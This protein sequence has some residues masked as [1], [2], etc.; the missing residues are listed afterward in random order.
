MNRLL[1]G[2]A[3]KTDLLLQLLQNETAVTVIDPTGELAKAAANQLPARLTQCAVYFDPTDMARPIGLNVLQN[4]P[5]DDR[6]RLTEQ[7]CTYFESMW[8]NG[9]GA[10]SNY[11]LANCLRLLLD[12][13]ETLLGILKLL[14]DPSFAETCLLRCKDP[15]VLKNWQVINSW[16]KKQRQAALA[17]LQNKVGTLLMSPTIRNIVGQ[18]RTTFNNVSIIFANLDR[19]KL[20]DLTARLLGGL[21]IA[22]STGHVVINDYGFFSAPVPLPQERFTLSLSF[23]DELPLKLKQEVLGIADKTIFK[24]NKHD[25]EELAFYV[26]ALNPRK[27]TELEPYE[28]V[29][30]YDGDIAPERPASLKRLKPLK[31]RSRACH[32]RP[33]LKVERSIKDYFG[34]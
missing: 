11:L 33:R 29:N 1:I 34:A 18:P 31:K 5:A 20:G 26:G 3:D 28:A 19:A 9:W 17:P 8:P 30:T 4:V 6:H 23:L 32:T 13:R 12:S 2:S 7:L 15:V 10:Q 21:L 16:D 22:R 14:T 25:A 27:L 24:T